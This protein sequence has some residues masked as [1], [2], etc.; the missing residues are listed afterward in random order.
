MVL[1]DVMVCSLV[2][3][4]GLCGFTSENTLILIFIAMTT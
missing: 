3:D 1:W 4:V 2:D